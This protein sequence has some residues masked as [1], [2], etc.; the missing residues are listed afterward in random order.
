MV[1]RNPLLFDPQSPQA[2]VSQKESG[3][4]PCIML[5]ILLDYILKRHT[6]RADASSGQASAFLPFG[7]AFG[8]LCAGSSNLSMKR[9]NKQAER[10]QVGIAGMPVGRSYSHVMAGTR[11][12]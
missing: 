8:E 9:F 7:L 12:Y 11:S 3:D 2:E 6:A 10:A 1:I 4:D 5:L